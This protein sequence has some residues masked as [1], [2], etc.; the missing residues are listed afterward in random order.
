MVVTRPRLKAWEAALHAHFAER[1]KGEAMEEAVLVYTHGARERARLPLAAV[2]RARLVL[3]TWEVFAA[4]DM[5]LGAAAEMGAWL[6][7]GRAGRG[8]DGR[9]AAPTAT[10]DV[11][12]GSRLMQLPWGRVL[13]DEAQRLRGPAQRAKCA[14]ALGRL[15][16]ADTH[17]WLLLDGT[18]L[19]TATTTMAGAAAGNGKRKGREGR[20][21]GPREDEKARGLMEA[22]FGEG[23]GEEEEGG[24]GGMARSHR[25]VGVFRLPA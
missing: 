12:V 16:A 20:E 19:L 15:R 14:E 24:G 6:G 3:T 1:Q 23:E 5:V 18:A 13:V 8:Q 10:A 17:R 11:A 2:A 4:R 21:W 22:L 9:R 25:A 7:A